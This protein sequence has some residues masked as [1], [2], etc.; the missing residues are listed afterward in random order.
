MFQKRIKLRLTDFDYNLPKAR[1]AQDPFPRR[2]YAKVL[3]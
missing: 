3:S 2:D 1:I